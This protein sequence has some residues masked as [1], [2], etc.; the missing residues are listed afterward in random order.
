MRV[1]VFIFL[2]NSFKLRLVLGQVVKMLATEDALLLSTR[3]IAPSAAAADKAKEKGKAS[4]PVSEAAA[5]ESLAEVSVEG[6][7]VQLSAVSEK[8]QYPGR[9]GRFSG[10]EIVR[11]RVLTN[12]LYTTS[13][14]ASA[15]PFKWDEDNDQVL[16]AIQQEPERLM[17]GNWFNVAYCFCVGLGFVL[18]SGGFQTTTDLRSHWKARMYQDLLLP[19]ARWCLAY[20][21]ADRITQSTVSSE[22]SLISVEAAGDRLLAV[23]NMIQS[24]VTVPGTSDEEVVS[25]TTMLSPPAFGADE[26]DDDEAGGGGGGQEDES[27]MQFVQAQSDFEDAINHVLDNEHASSAQFETRVGQNRRAYITAAKRLTDIYLEAQANHSGGGRFLD[28][29]QMAAY[30]KAEYRKSIAVFEGF[31]A[32]I[33]AIKRD[34]TDEVQIDLAALS[35][36][37]AA[38]IALS[39]SESSGEGASPSPSKRVVSPLSKKAKLVA[40]DASPAEVTAAA[41][42]KQLRSPVALVVATAVSP[43]R[44]PGSGAS[45]PV[46]ARKRFADTR[47]S[48]AA[49]AVIT[50]EDSPPRSMPFP[51]SPP[52]SP[53]PIIVPGTARPLPGISKEDPIILAQ[54]S[55]C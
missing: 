52:S 12:I 40:R 49:A 19:V 46:P 29:A 33:N 5:A 45:S 21:P 48:A 7:P 18:E 54:I 25:V 34:L 15:L 32:A 9:E 53:G 11:H 10:E 42:A 14:I 39:D 50:L 13:A 2:L 6:L 35:P 27:V 23:M 44:G 4:D 3:S 17:F 37:A 28:F 24:A 30:M 51:P 22:E 55:H 1:S 8:L 26:D 38:A 36:S 43:S 41:A 31:K 47:L 16:E 20:S